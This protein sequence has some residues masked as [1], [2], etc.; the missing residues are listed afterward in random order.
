MRLRFSVQNVGLDRV[1][2]SEDLDH[3]EL[4]CWVLSAR[5]WDCRDLVRTEV[6]VIQF[7][8]LD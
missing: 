6:N 4:V 2:G 3:S 7:Q 8:C 5:I 1:E